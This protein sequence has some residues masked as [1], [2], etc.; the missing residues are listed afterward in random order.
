MVPRID[1]PSPSSR[2]A[3]GPEG[4]RPPAVVVLG[5]AL[6][7]AGVWFAGVPAH[8]QDPATSTRAADFGK[9]VRPI[10]EEYC[11]LCHG[12]ET[13]KAELR[14]DVLDPD[15]VN[16]PDAETWKLALDMIQLGEMPRGLFQ[17]VDEE[18]R[19][20]VGWL[21]ESLKE[22]AHARKGER[23]VVLRRLNREQFSN[24]LQDLLGVA[25]DFGQTLPDDAQSE[26]GFRNNGEVLQASPL[27]LETYQ[28]IAREALDQAIVVGAKPAVTRYR[29]TFGKGVGVGEVAGST[30]GYQ[31]VPLSTDDF[32]VDLL[33]ERGMPRVGATP[34]E[35]AGLDAVKRKISVGLRGSAQDRFHSVEE[36]LILYSALPHKEV[37]PGSWQ[38]PSPNVKMEMQ[39]CFPE[40]G[41]FVFRVTASRGYLVQQRR[42]LLVSLEDPVPR[43]LLAHRTAGRE[44]TPEQIRAAQPARFGPWFRAGP[45]PAR[46]GEEARDASAVDPKAALDFAAPLADGATRWTEAGSTDGEVQRYEDRIG[47]VYLARVIE[48]PSPRTI[49]VSLGSDDALWVWLNGEQILAQDVRRGVAPDQLRLS[50]NLNEGRNE[51]LLKIVNYGG[52][53]GS[54]HRLLHDGTLAAPRSFALDVEENGLVFAAERS[55]ERSNLRFEGGALVPNDVPQPSSAELFVHLREGGYY[56]FDLV[57]P[58]TPPE[59]MGSIRFSVGDMRLDLRPQLTEEEL[60][61]GT[62]VS[63]LGAGYLNAGAQ[64][65]TL[66]GPFF[67]GFSHLVLTPVESDHPLVARLEAH[68]DEQES[69]ETPAIRSYL[70][71]RTDDGMDYRTFDESRAVDAALG[72]AEVYEFIGRLENLPIPEPD[73]GDLEILSGIMVLGLWNDHLVKS[74]SATG[75]PLLLEAM[76]FEAPYHPVWPPVS[77]TR[78]FFDHPSRGDEEAYTRA[79]VARFAERAFRRPLVPEELDR[80]LAFWRSVKDDYDQY[81]HG[82]RE[83]L[84]AVL[85]SPSFLFLAEPRLAGGE[86]REEAAEADGRF[87]EFGLANRLAYFL[88]NSPP[89]EE[90]LR[91]AEEGR[92]RGEIAEQADRLLDDPRTER[93]VRVFARE[94]LRL[95]RLESVSV[96]VGSFP[97]FTRFVKADM[98]EE[99]VAFLHRVIAED[100][101]LLT[102]I[103]SDF[104]MLNQNLAEFYGIE[105]VQGTHFRPVAIT[106]EQRRG[107]LLSQGAFLTGHSDGSEPHPIKRAVWMKEKILGDPPLPPPPN[108]P[109]LE[110]DAPELQSLTLKQKI[111]LHRDKPSCYD[112]HASFDPYGIAFERFNAVGLYQP[113]RREQII[114]ASTTLPDGTAVDGVGELKRW[115]REEKR[116]AVASSVIEHLFAYALGRDLHFAD[117]EELGGI[118]DQVRSEDYRLRAVIR[119]IVTSPSFLQR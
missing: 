97:A 116:D 95:D 104:A 57:H 18:R 67:V 84:I 28:R 15:M 72:E 96:N 112:C 88:W 73:T 71:T 13:Q 36:G 99:T 14:L 26:M 117:E 115:L 105:G 31:S 17:P 62:V 100:L 91:L 103:D 9:E 59:A 85:C 4:L 10:L 77:H 119:G 12:E 79:V 7:C 46:T 38:G 16:G 113:E 78:I 43:V 90:L 89:D 101:P 82:V 114:D 2:A 19:R 66:G 35:Q 27:H 50:L 75:P 54:Y 21:S 51:L 74:S 92:L 118:L 58:A 69:A 22:A 93:F 83:V 108:V 34:E 39:R 6:A 110:D 24:T 52:A 80:Y 29:V 98:Q 87:A 32:V 102:L 33:D 11:F 86:G 8:G 65:I 20:L 64:E 23:R 49:D 44:P 56:Q 47:A 37:A 25:V 1:R 5:T 63:T 3:S 94:W 48:A 70:G 106:P 111:E 107:G 68:A 61:Q 60:A 42:E 53:F 109:E 45:I 81:E 40:K 30:G 55:L 41:D 76:E